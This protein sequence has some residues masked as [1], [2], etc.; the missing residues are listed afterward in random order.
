[1]HDEEETAKR[2]KREEQES[3]KRKLEEAPEDKKRRKED[4]DMID[5]LESA[6]LVGK[7]AFGQFKELVGTRMSMQSR[8]QGSWEERLVGGIWITSDAMFLKEP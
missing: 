5:M 1:M 3:N 6:G 8:S 7:D 2:R 4:S